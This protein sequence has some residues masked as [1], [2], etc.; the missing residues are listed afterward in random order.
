MAQLEK[1]MVEDRTSLPKIVMVEGVSALISSL[2]VAPFVTVIDRAI[3][4]NASGRQRL[5]SALVEGAGTLLHPVKLMQQQSFRLVWAVYLGTYLVA[6]SM[7][8]LCDWKHVPWQVPTF[9]ASSVVNVALSLYKDTQF[10]KM[11][12]APGKLP[13]PLPSIAYGLFTIRD[14]MTVGASFNLPILAGDYLKN[15]VKT[16]KMTWLKGR[17]YTVAQVSV[18]MAIQFLSTPLHLLALD[19]YNRP[20]TAQMVRAQ[21]A[22]G[23]AETEKPPSMASRASFVASEY[24]KSVLA[25][26]ARILPAFGVGGVLNSRLRR[27]GYSMLDDSL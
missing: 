20:T 3:V 7:H 2:F 19:Y 10:A 13:A 12:A 1:A 17:E 26:M 23:V 15:I 8:G 5:G 24:P 18:P 6:N 16:G 21:N 4:S 9:V 22:T 14:C 11:F 27:R 25:R